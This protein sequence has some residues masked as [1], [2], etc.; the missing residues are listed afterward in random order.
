MFDEWWITPI[1]IPFIDFFLSRWPMCT[2]RVWNIQALL[3]CMINIVS[4]QLWAFLN[5]KIKWI[6]SEIRIHDANCSW[7]QSPFSIDWR[8]VRYFI[9]VIILANELAEFRGGN[10]IL[11][12]NHAY[13]VIWLV[14]VRVCA[15][16]PALLS[17]MMKYS[18]SSCFFVS[19]AF[20]LYNA[21]LIMCGGE[22]KKICSQTTEPN[23]SVHSINYSAKLLLLLLFMSWNLWSSI[24]TRYISIVSVC[25]VVFVDSGR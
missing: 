7:Y 18:S 1:F 4:I 22:L 20:I 12:L 25:L 15:R 5:Q 13:F 11:N 3:I 21:N 8:A 2:C 14:R 6:D 23:S 10:Q 19:H 9:A 24:N 16:A 17:P